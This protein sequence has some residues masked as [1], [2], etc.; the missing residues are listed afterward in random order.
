[1][2]RPTA[3]W[4][5][6]DHPPTLRAPRP[7]RPSRRRHATERLSWPRRDLR[8]EP[9]LQFLPPLVKPAVR[10]RRPLF[11]RGAQDRVVPVALDLRDF[12]RAPGRRDEVTRR[13]LLR[14][15]LSEQ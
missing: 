10:Q 2:V 1:M 15:L 3:S 5:L 4:P 9:P 8:E 13:Q 14:A 11:D 6:R 7:L 12:E